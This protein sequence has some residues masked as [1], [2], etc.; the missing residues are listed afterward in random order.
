MLLSGGTEPSTL[1]V[2]AGATSLAAALAV[3]ALGR[4]VPRKAGRAELERPAQF[5]V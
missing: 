1:F 3:F 4:H 5:P 2:V